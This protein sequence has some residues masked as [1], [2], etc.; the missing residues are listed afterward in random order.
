MQ[1]A[2]LQVDFASRNRDAPFGQPSTEVAGMGHNN[3]W[4]LPYKNMY[5]QSFRTEC[6]MRAHGALDGRRGVLVCVCWAAGGELQVSINGDSQRAQY[7]R[8]RHES[9]FLSERD[10]DLVPISWLRE[11]YR[12]PV[13]R[14]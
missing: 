4:R 10:D 7:N 1:A 6:P 5:L 8:D 9:H 14:R 12:R 2:A 11:L 13:V 3:C